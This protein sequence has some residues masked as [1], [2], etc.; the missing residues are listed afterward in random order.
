MTKNPL[1]WG[2]GLYLATMLAFFIVYY[3]FA[4]ANY[5]STTM[6]VNAFGMTFLYAVAGFASTYWL[7]RGK[8]ITYP[9]AFK[10][11]FITLFTGGLLSV[12]SIFAFLNYADTDARDL[13]NHQYIQT[14]LDNL[15]QSYAKLR[16]EALNQKDQSKVRELEDNYKGAKLARETA[17]KEDRNY[18]SF[19]YMSGIFGGFLLFYLLLSIVIAGFLKNKKRYE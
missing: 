1:A 3:F 16:G 4:N 12:L 10:Q 17:M 7:R 13:L 15:D 6:Q 2:F 9:Q 8:Y 18:F 5:W 14:E 19:R 11:C